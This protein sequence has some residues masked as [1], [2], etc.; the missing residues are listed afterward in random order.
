MNI[1][2]LKANYLYFQTFVE[3]VG[4]DLAV[5][6][7]SETW[8]YDWNFN[9]YNI[10]GY[11]FIEAH[12][13]SRKVG[14]VG[15]YVR[16][17]IPFQHRHDLVMADCKCECIFIK[18]DKDISK[19]KNLI[20]GVIN[21]PPP[22]PPTPTPPPPPP[23]PHLPHQEIYWHNWSFP[24]VYVD[25]SSNN[26]KPMKDSAQRNTSEINKQA[27]REVLATLDW[28]EIY[29]ENNTQGTFSLFHSI[30]V[31][32][33]NKHFPKRKRKQ[34]IQ[35]VNSGFLRVLRNRLKLRINF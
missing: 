22:P 21:P 7:L 32:L 10:L 12:R 2:S 35:H 3:N 1:A 18:V 24:V 4:L 30:A 31:K 15:M 9:L 23:P 16:D 5:I 20:I 17:V 27:F 6:G 34:F 13:P 11:D 33:Y 26:S 29:D 28:K 8:L 19:S 14:G 25:R